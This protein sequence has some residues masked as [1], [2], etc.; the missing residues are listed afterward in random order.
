M[1]DRN[2]NV[3]IDGYFAV[4][5]K[6]DCPHLATALDADLAHYREV[7]I[8]SPCQDCD[9]VGE[10]WVC[11][12]C[13]QVKC[14]RY[15]SSHGL[16]HY[17]DTNHSLAMSF[18]DLS[19]WCH[20]CDSYLEHDSLDSLLRHFRDLKFGPDVSSLASNLE[21][22][23][24]EEEP[25]EA[26]EESKEKAS[27]FLGTKSIRDLAL[28]LKNSEYKKI[29][30]MAGAGISVSAGIPDFRSTASG[31]YAQLAEYN[32]SKP[33]LVFEINYFR[34]SPEVFFKVVKSLVGDFK[35]T[36][37]HYFFKLLE[38]KGCLMKIYTQNI[39]GLEVKAGVSRDKIT[40]AHGHMESSHC[41]V[42]K[43]E[44]DNALMK[45]HLENGTVAWCEC[46]APAKPD[47]VFFGEALNPEFYSSVQMLR[48]ADLLI[49]CG[50]SLKVFP[51][52]GLVTQV[53]EKVPRVMIN[54]E[55]SGQSVGMQYDN[56]KSRDVVFIGDTDEVFAEIARH[57]DWE[58]V[59]E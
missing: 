44:Y 49:V 18:S 42:C 33:E 30:I 47:V 12:I 36:P 48:E 7:N 20:L 8:R 53:G 24:I 57:A 25:E 27:G 16:A 59:C 28:A 21:E 46:G 17:S 10:N 4:S 22:M 58:L 6:R 51:F 29:A 52:A 26:E 31:L 39:D 1:S 3:E 56:P 14:S 2:I 43:A 35:P 41:S 55:A 37:T 54:R 32:L 15:V 9:N 5:P 11:L 23:K 40:F 50:T 13:Q 38:Q 19:V 45:T 34:N